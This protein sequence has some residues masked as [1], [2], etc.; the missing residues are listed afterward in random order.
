MSPAG[1][2]TTWVEQLRAG[3]HAAAQRL[4]QRYFPRLVGLARR[5]LQGVSRRAADEEDVAFSAFHSLSRGVER[6]LKLI[7]SLWKK[8]V[9]G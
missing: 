4:W 8:S 5:R 3:D 9:T 2:V 1:S 6:Q 7:R